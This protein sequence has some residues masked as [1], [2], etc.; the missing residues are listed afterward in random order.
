LTWF[1]NSHPDPDSDSEL[2][3]AESRRTLSV[4][5]VRGDTDVD[6]D[7]DVVVRR[8]DVVIVERTALMAFSRMA[9]RWRLWS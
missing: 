3:R 9:Q 2:R 8:D 1:V 5:R 4:A 7:G 6:G